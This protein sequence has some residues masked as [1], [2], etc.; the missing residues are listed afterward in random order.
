MNPNTS[1][2]HGR[3]LVVVDVQ[4][5]FCPG[6]S[7]A[8]HRGDEVVPYINRIRDD[9]PLVVFTQD[10]HPPGHK[11]FASSN[12]GT[13]IGQLIDVPGGKQVMW[14]DHCVQGTPGADFHRD[15]RR[16]PDDP[17]FH[18]GQ[19]PGVDS[20][21]GFLDNDRRN[22]TG[23]QAFLKEKAVETVDIVGLATDYCVKFTV[24]D[25]LGFGFRVNVHQ[26]GCRAV[27][28]H[29]DDE[30]KAWQEMQDAGAVLLP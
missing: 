5:D 24:L 26:Q 3:A 13:E 9:F 21:S 29:P 30:A 14:P 6:G 17:V 4:N 10:W 15:L 27:N 12:P 11:S 8:V 25:A 19:L 28:L 2:T 7:L 20:Y 16:N 23:L 1:P 18:K 22:E